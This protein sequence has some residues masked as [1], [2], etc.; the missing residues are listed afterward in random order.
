MTGECL[1]DVAP[2]T[3]GYRVPENAVSAFDCPLMVM[4][5]VID[6]CSMYVNQAH[7]DAPVGRRKV[8]IRHH[9]TS[10]ARRFLPSDVRGS[11][12]LGL[13]T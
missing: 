2:G 1:G 11:T 4:L 13:V 6:Q 9:T 7:E 5:L 12:L 10:S 8:A 3:R